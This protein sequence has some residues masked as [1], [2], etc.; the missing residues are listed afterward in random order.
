MVIQV[1][2]LKTQDAYLLLGWRSF[3]SN[4]NE[5]VELQKCLM[6]YR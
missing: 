6:D 3:L 5:R 4:F 2:L 1:D